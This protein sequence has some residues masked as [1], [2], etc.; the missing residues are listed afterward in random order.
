MITK[1]E[2]D[3]ILTEINGIFSKLDARIKA[4]EDAKNVKPTTTTNK[5]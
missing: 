5:K 2:L 4:L 1:P 3:K